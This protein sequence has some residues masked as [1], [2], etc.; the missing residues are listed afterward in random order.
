MKTEYSL[1]K[2][3][4]KGNVVKIEMSRYIDLELYHD[5]ERNHPFYEEMV[6]E[7]CKEIQ[8][9][10]KGKTPLKILE[11]G[12]G[13]G[14]LT[15]ELLKHDSVLVDAVELDE[16]CCKLLRKHIEDERCNCI[17][18]DAETF[19]REE[20]Y[21][22]VI[23]AFAHDHIPYDHRFQFVKNIKRN[24]KAGGIYIMGGEVL[25][26]FK[27]EEERK[28]S[29]YT[30]HCYII[31]RALKEKYFEVA[32]IEINALKSGLETE[33][34]FKRHELMFENEM[35]SSGLRLCKKKKIGPLDLE[36]VGGVFVYV[37][38]N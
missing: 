12:A 4:F 27:N 17:C 29:L 8:R 14:L 6:E 21:D 31:E 7:Q 18:D 34:D 13:T 38:R 30:Y 23:S 33:G 36:D 3:S 22:V 37:Y 2:D 28:K 5:V 26:Y 10:S 19:C 35:A 9:F 24:L 20:K 25:P 15:A 16:E 1:T 32:Q 11:I